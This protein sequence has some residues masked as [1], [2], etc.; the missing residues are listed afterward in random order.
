MQDSNI[1]RGKATLCFPH[2]C[3]LSH[4]P[5][6]DKKKRT[7]CG[8]AAL[9]RPGTVNFQS[10]LLKQKILWAKLPPQTSLFMETKKDHNF[11]VC[12]LAAD[13]KTLQNPERIKNLADVNS[14]IIS[15]AAM[16]YGL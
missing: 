4:L 3:S 13:G 7:V 8:V 1:N 9:S 12:M 6:K 10:P 5:G 15:E 16:P 11:F 14:V 2:G